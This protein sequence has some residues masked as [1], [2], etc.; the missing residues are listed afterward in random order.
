MQ[1]ATT[2]PSIY[3]ADESTLTLNGVQFLVKDAGITAT[4]IASSVFVRI[5]DSVISDA[6]EHYNS[7][8]FFYLA[9]TITII[10]TANGKIKVPAFTFSGDLKTSN[11]VYTAYWK[12]T[13]Q[14]GS[15]AETQ[16]GTDQ[17][18]NSASYVTK[19]VVQSTDLTG[20]V[21]DA[22]VFRIYLK[23]QNHGT[24]NSYTRNNSSNVNAQSL[25]SITSA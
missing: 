18:T 17:S 16:I 8:Q 11:A 22:I 7:Q 3:N 5:P 1:I 21:N 20:A 25:S 12:V 6:N 10:P 23:Q 14:I 19:S 13:Y 9:S 15:G 2:I 24:D 4:K